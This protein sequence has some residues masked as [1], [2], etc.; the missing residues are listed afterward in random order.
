MLA[1]AV[2]FIW[3]FCFI[4]VIALLIRRQVLRKQLAEKYKFLRPP[5]I[6]AFFHPYCNSGGGGER[7]LW[8]GINCLLRTY[9]SLLIFIYTN[10]P[11][12]LDS[13]NRVFRRVRETF[14]ISIGD[15]K[16]VNFVRLRSEPLLRASLYSF[17]TLAGQAFGSIVATFECLVRLPPDFYIDSTGFSFTIPL[18]SWFIGARCGAYI[19]FPTI[20]ADMV[21]RVVQHSTATSYNNSSRI[22]TSQFL[23]TLK[24]LYYIFFMGIYGWTGSSVNCHAVAVNSTWT[25]RHIESLFG[26]R[27][28]LLYP[29]C[30]C[31]VN[32]I[33]V[34]EKRKPW[35]ISI[36][37]F[38]PEK[39]HL[40][41]HVLLLYCFT[42]Y[43]SST[44]W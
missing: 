42:S 27:P 43:G 14:D 10:D 15:T 38:R 44:L 17:L 13:P 6:L 36:G 29:P 22:R 31:L 33:D 1:F 3:T 8:T 20:S 5:T 24:Q 30:P 7:V 21:N 28:L 2:I 32:G 19:H 18:F 25:R 35:I 26:S 41:S 23:T 39:N 34:S 4:F 37:Q 9:P 40:V 12:C 16:R 11:S